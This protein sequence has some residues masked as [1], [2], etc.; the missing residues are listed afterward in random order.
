LSFVSGTYQQGFNYPNIM[1][2]LGYLPNTMGSLSPVTTS[3][4]KS[5][6]FFYSITDFSTGITSTGFALQGLCADPG[7]AWLTSI[8]V[9]GNG[10]TLTGAS[11]TTYTY[12][13]NSCGTGSALWGWPGYGPTQT[14]GTLTLLHH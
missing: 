12:S 9:A 10:V 3:D 6:T 1:L 2:Y 7:R 14:S 5:I 13:P 11:A 8:A 4:G